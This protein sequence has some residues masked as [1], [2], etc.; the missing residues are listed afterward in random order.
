MS[1]Q[2]LIVASAQQWFQLLCQNGAHAY[3]VH[4]NQFREHFTYLAC[5]VLTILVHLLH[6]VFLTHQCVETLVSLRINVGRQMLH[7]VVNAFGHQVFAQLIE[8]I[9]H[10]R[11]VLLQ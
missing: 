11:R 3:R 4:L 7:H 8:D 6:H 1:V 9:L 5:Q 2:R 10:Q